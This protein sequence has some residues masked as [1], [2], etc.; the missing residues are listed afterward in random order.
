MFDEP[1]LHSTLEAADGLTLT[2][3]STGQP[4][5][6]EAT[7]AGTV[8]GF[9]AGSALAAG[10]SYRFRAG[11]EITDVAVYP[12]V[13]AAEVTFG[14]AE[15]STAEAPVLDALPAVVCAE[16]LAVSGT[17]A[18][19][20]TVRVRDGDL[21]FTFS[22]T[23][24]YRSGTLGYGPLGSAGWS[25]NLFAHLR[26]IETTREVE[27][28]DGRGNVWRFL[29]RDGG[30]PPAGFDDD[31]SGSYF[32]PR[33]LYLRLQK[34]SAEQ[35][36]RLLSREH[37]SLFFDARGRLVAF[38]D[39]H[40]RNAPVDEQGST[41]RFRYDTF[42]QLVGIKD[43]LGRN[44]RLEYFE[45]PRPEDDGGDGPRYG[46][47]EKITD[48]IDRTVEYEYSED[49]TLDKVLLVEVTNPTEHYSGY[50]Y[51]DDDR[52]ANEYRYDPEEGSPTPR[53]TPSPS[54]TATSPSC[55][56]RASCCRISS[57]GS[58]ACR[59]CGSAT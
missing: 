30:E 57:T 15:E 59:G 25:A 10:E 54:S 32:V 6:G 33:G 42:G 47:L 40:R 7:V 53:T 24:T 9:A 48:F 41:I 22:F 35:G 55:A 26:E 3:L 38:S 23:R 20:T 43:D 50:E 21:V 14:V 44:Y 5:V 13:E 58:P 28:H 29:P 17:A 19:G 51:V 36:W 1:I 39:R 2:R 46:L 27:Y 11:A 34:L 31:P 18:T 56:W 49:R 45:D 4:A 52:P 16:E 12:L 37:H 8:V